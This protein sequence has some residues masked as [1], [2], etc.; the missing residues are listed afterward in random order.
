MKKT[1]KIYVAYS[2]TIEIDTE[3]DVVKDYHS[4]SEMIDDLAGHRFLPVMP[5]INSGG[6]KVLDFELIES[7]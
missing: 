5:V 4:E 6:V 7:Q 2:V 1:V 3:N